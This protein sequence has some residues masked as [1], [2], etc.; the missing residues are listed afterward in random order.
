MARV[1]AADV[2]GAAAG[3]PVTLEVRGES[4]AGGPLPYFDRLLADLPQTDLI[5]GYGMTETCGGCVHEGRPLPGAAVRVAADGRIVPEGEGLAAALI[6]RNF[7]FCLEPECGVAYARTQRSER[8][9]LATLGVDSRSTAT[10]IDWAST[11][12]CRR[13]AAR[14]SDAPKPSVPSEE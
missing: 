14:V 10:T 12:K 7:L 4:R 13:S 3:Q 2:A 5:Q 9:K 8:M 11:L 6:G 1:V